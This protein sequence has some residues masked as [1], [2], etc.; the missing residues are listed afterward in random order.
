ME[1]AAC[2]AMNLE[3]EIRRDEIRLQSKRVFILELIGK[4]ENIDYE[5]V[6][7][8]RYFEACGWH[9]IATTMHYTERWL[10]TLH[11]RALQELNRQ[12]AK[13]DEMP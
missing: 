3:R 5:T 8:K 10:H 1:D 12:M 11:G 4:L 7:I 9:D 13:C 6:L 2:K